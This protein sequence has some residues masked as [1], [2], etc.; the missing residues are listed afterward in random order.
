MAKRTLRKTLD[1][2]LPIFQAKISLQ[3][4]A[5]PIWRRVEMSD[6]DLEELH[7]II[8]IVMGWEEMHMHAF[9]IDGEQ[10]GTD[11]DFECDSR[12]VRL[13]EVL[14]T[15]H[16]RF[17]YDYD[18]GDDWEHIIDIEKTLPAEEGV[19]YPRCVAGER[20]CPPED[21]GGPYGYPYLLEKLHDPE[22]EEHEEAVEWVGDDFDPEKF[23]LEAVND[24]LLRV[25]RWLGR[26][27]GKNAKSAFTKGQVVQVK[28]GVVHDQYPDIPLGG[29]VGK[30]KRIGWLIPIGYAVHWTRPTLD[31]AP[32]VYFKR[33][34]RDELKVHR[35]W[36][37]EDQLEVAAEETPVAMEQPTSI[38][39]RPLSNDDPEHRI[40]LV[41]GLTSDDPLPE[42]DEQTQR[43]FLAY[44]KS[45][46]T[47]PF[48]A[49][50][51]AASVLG[52]NKSGEI[53]VVGLADPPIDPREGIAL[54]ARKR[55]HP[56]QV[57][58]AVIHADEDDPNFQFVE[59]Y[60]YW[61]WEVQDYEEQYE[62]PAQFPIGT[63]AYYG[64]DDKITTKIVA[65]V[66]KEEGA[67]PIIKRWVATDVTTN[68]KVATEIDRFFK[69]H[70][71]KKVGM[72]EGNMGCPHEEGEDFPNGSDCPF[73]PWW[74]GKQGSGAKE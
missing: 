44:L 68:P 58:L 6:C 22:H 38:V 18:F 24:E 72:S 15:G 37:E 33:C 11:G 20:A 61:L 9:V 50:Y 19:R 10:Y 40:R 62:E 67:E 35:H 7:D 29:W 17:E 23:D 13:S 14:E 45:H 32:S 51:A 39:T 52:S 59:D 53:Q 64:P 73:C 26:R 4:I 48:K 46:L 41:F 28:H 69:K 36:L 54:E 57:P 70:G 56:F 2:T 43:Q 8:Q 31:Q 66:I 49:E 60:T 12:F 47:F 65:G 5:P 3:H 27:R 42:S 34:Q 63:I 74:K 71:V 25:R 1:L 16:T 21:S 55:A 30:I